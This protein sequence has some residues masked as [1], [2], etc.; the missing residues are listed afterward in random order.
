M[1]VGA[2][3]EGHIQMKNN[4][5]VTGMCTQWIV[6]PHGVGSRSPDTELGAILDM[7][8]WVSFKTSNRDVE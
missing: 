7:V 8:I 3:A 1:V 6:V 4:P 5:L 2:E